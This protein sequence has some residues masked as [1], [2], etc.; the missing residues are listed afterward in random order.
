MVPQKYR[1]PPFPSNLR[2]VRVTL[3]NGRIIWRRMLPIAH[4]EAGPADDAVHSQ[5]PEDKRGHIDSDSGDD[6]PPPRRLQLQLPLREPLAVS[7]APTIGPGPE[8]RGLSTESDDD[9]NEA[10]YLLAS[11]SPIPYRS[12]AYANLNDASSP[13]PQRRRTQ[14]ENIVYT[15]SH[16]DLVL[17]DEDESISAA[18]NRPVPK[19][20][21]PDVKVE[22]EA[23][24]DERIESVARPSSTAP[25][26]A[27]PSRK[28]KYALVDSDSDSDTARD[29]KKRQRED[30]L[31]A[32]WLSNRISGFL[33]IMGWSSGAPQIRRENSVEVEQERH[34][35]RA[36]LEFTEEMADVQRR[37]AGYHAEMQE[38]R[39]RSEG[40]PPSPQRVMD[41]RRR[42]GNERFS[43]E[44]SP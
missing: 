30:N 6:I 28:R 27:G 10:N 20:S 17:V 37:Q 43:G 3:P 26:E 39:R 15:G 22:E 32:S 40:L 31:T 14:V 25:P 5:S 4:E 8:H 24:V 42:Q 9:A 36:R 16:C 33:G 41:A 7:P 44:Q 38:R 23:P 34:S 12:R 11:S 2:R 35:A 29:M 21:T 13:T 1:S 18:R 19:E